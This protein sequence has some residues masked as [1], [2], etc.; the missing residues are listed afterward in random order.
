MVDKRLLIS[1]VLCLLLVSC[2]GGGGSSSPAVAAG[3]GVT[4]SGSGGSSGSSSGSTADSCG[5]SAQIDFVEEVATDWYYWYDELAAV[6]ADAYSSAQA[7]L[8]AI[9]EPIT[10]DNSGRD[11]GF[12]YLT[13]V[14]EDEARFTSGAYYGFGFRYA[15]LNNDQEFYFSDTFEGGPAHEAG[16]RR[17]QRLLGIDMGDGF[18]SWE[19]I[20]ARGAPSSEVFGPSDSPVSRIFRVDDNGVES[21]IE[22][23]KAE[24]TTPPLAGEPLLIPREGLPPVGYIHFRTFIDAA[25]GPLRDAASQFASAGVTDV[26]VDLRYNGGGLVRVAQTFLNLLGGDIADGELSYIINFND[27]RQSNNDTANFS[28]EPETFTPL[29]IA[30]IT[31]TGTASASEMVINGLAPHIEMA[32]VGTDTYGKAVGQS[33]FDLGGD[34]DTRLRLISFE[35]QNG[36]GQGG[37]YTGLASTG[38]FT[39][40][41]AEDDVKRPFGDLNEDSLQTALAWLDGTL[42]KASATSTYKRPPRPLSLAPFDAVWPMNKVPP[43]NP[44]G[45]VRSF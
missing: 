4:G 43:L 28:V 17:S 33:A 30:F 26:V 37:Y 27:K 44:D 9:V 18:E 12:S 45:S 11:P 39:L 3:G 7:Y 22:V 23:T 42:E 32:M 6:D 19:S 38:R 15:L 16:L 34:C 35:I 1:T 21:D 20:V 41:E 10:S 31:R 8:D 24:L 36:E 25:D 14:S 2:G 13:T 40:Y 29:R 5:V